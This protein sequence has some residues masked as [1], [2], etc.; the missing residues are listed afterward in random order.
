MRTQDR[1]DAHW[2]VRGM[3]TVVDTRERIAMAALAFID[4][5]GVD[6]LTLRALGQS[7]GMHHTAVY[8]H[9]ASRD[10]VL[11]AA[12]GIVIQAAL[13]R[14]EPLP[15][16]P[17]ERLLALA[18]SLRAELRAHPAVSFTYLLPVGV[19]AASPAA[20]TFV[21]EI[22]GALKDGGLHG[23]ALLLNFRLLEGYVLGMASFDFSGAPD[24]L[25]SRRLRYR[26]YVDPAFEAA[27]RD[28]EGVDALNEAA[29]D[30]GLVILVDACLGAGR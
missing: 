23:D 28:T 4:E 5:H 22:I 6:A 27:T 15:A 8:R 3:A 30:R 2:Y 20:E 7:I 1:L 24:H 19:I 12:T 26:M 18:R 29:F 25:E 10:Q 14:A 13:N 21:G 11:G 16:D 17:R 9:F